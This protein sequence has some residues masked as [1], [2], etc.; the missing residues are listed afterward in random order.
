MNYTSELSGILRDR[1]TPADS[2]AARTLFEYQAG[3]ASVRLALVIVAVSLGMFVTLIPF[4]RTPLA[5]AP[6]FIPLHQPVLVINDL[7][8]MTL[9][10]AYFNLTRKHGILILACGYL[11]SA[12]MATV[13]LLSFPGVFAPGGL[14]GAGP[15]GTGYLHVFWHLGFPVSVITYSFLKQADRIAD[16]PGRAT[17]KAVALT[18]A[19][20]AVLGMLGTAGSDWL[21]QMLQD[22]RYSSAF[23]IGRYGQ[24]IV[25][26][27]A[28]AILFTRRSASTMDMWLVVVLSAWF[29]EIGLVSV[30]NAGRWDVGFY[31]GRAYGLV[32]SSFVL[33]MLLIEHGRMYRDLAEAQATAR[34]AARLQETQQVLGLA[35]E[36]GRMGVF[37]WD[38]VRDRAWWSPKVEHD[39]LGLQPGELVEQPNALTPY[40]F[41]EDRERLRAQIRDCIGNRS[42]CDVEFRLRDAQGQARWASA[43]GKA[44][45]TSG[46]RRRWYSASWPTSR[47]ASA[48]KRR[49][50]RWKCISTRWRTN[51]RRSPGWRGRTAGSTGSTGAGTSTPGCR[52]ARPKAGAGGR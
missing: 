18:L 39:I 34:T 1:A 6:W 9:L 5:A 14:L 30:F 8:T 33:I 19:C 13:H 27:L 10:L 16:R 42:A 47:S 45:T 49:P 31:A 43:R 48:A 12:V 17:A 38:L 41:P 46:A 2:Q 50:P 52:R 3:P 20:A 25:T 29:F 26:G 37:S 23:N 32:A 28:L 51:C 11:Y 21:P 44:A 7:I 35:L 4:A 36:A 22:D 15:Q 40:V 24:W